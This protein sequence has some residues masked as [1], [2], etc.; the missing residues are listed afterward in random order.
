ML[1]ILDNWRLALFGGNR[2]PHPRNVVRSVNPQPLASSV[3]STERFMATHLATAVES[4]VSKMLLL[5]FLIRE[6]LVQVI[7]LKVKFCSHTW[8]GKQHYYQYLS[9]DVI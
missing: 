3:P 9:N 1:R 5:A 2:R 7:G 6:F 8:Y 4:L